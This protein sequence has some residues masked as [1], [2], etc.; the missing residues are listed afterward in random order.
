MGD[1]K[2]E[3]SRYE[4]YRRVV[5]AVAATDAF[6][7]EE[8]RERCAEAQP[9][10]ITRLVKALAA[11]GFL[12][13][14]GPTS[15]RS[16]RWSPKRRAFA[17]D[18]WI[19]ARIRGTRITVSPP[20]ERPRERLIREGAAALRTA[21]LVAI[22]VRSGRAGESA[23]QAGEKVAGQ[24]DGRLESLT[25][26]GRGELK[27]ISPVIADTAYC[28]IMAGIELGRRVVEAAGPAGERPVRIGGPE[29]ALRYCQSTF[30][31]LAA[32][33][34][35][36]EFHVVTLD[37][38]HQVIANHRVTRGTLDGSPAPPREVFRP[39]IRDA[40]Y[41]VI[42][43]HNHPS[44]DARP[45]AADLAVTRRLEDAGENLGIHVL[46][47]VIVA[48]RGSLSMRAYRAEAGGRD[49]APPGRRRR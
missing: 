5:A 17:A 28:Q 18:R 35:Q 33:G 42:L 22:L 1:P 47:H 13:S 26:A 24:F 43:V 6:S 31:R 19:D 20:A 8:V 40:A 7:I 37:T 2:D 21:E 34:D 9:G 32:D 36:E 4:R 44:G 14:V 10:L 11:D 30:G 38:R 29:D 25:R 3:Q 27:A 49:P 48:R 15:R 46:D 39:A 23:L 16:Y 41:A 12:E 45:S